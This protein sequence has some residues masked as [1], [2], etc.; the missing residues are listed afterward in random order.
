VIGED[1]ESEEE[2]FQTFKRSKTFEFGITGKNY[3]MLSLCWS[4]DMNVLY[5]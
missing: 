2:Q 4:N 3:G 5:Y 1:E